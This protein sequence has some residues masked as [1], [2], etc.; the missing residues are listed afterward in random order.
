MFQAAVWSI[1]F[2][3]DSVFLK[4]H[5]IS[6]VNA[7]EN[8]PSFSFEC[9]ENRFKILGDVTGCKVLEAEGLGK[10]H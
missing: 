3:V 2:L 5:C 8:L 9:I 10:E 6:K 4:F 1:V 7:R